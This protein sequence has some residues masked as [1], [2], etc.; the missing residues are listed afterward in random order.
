MKLLWVFFLCVTENRVQS[1]LKLFFN[2]IRD[3][4]NEPL[5][6][7]LQLQELKGGGGVGGK[8]DAASASCEK[9]PIPVMEI[10][11]SATLLSILPI[12]DN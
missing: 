9:H 1:G 12:P 6:L 2:L 4:E 11:S 8:P 10:R 3:P 7:Q 5:Q